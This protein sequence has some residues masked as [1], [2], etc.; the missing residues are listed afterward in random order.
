MT[1]R[2]CSVVE[3]SARLGVSTKSMNTWL[4][5]VR[6]Q[7]AKSGELDELRKENA[8][9]KSELNQIAEERDISK[10][11]PS[12]KTGNAASRVISRA[13]D[14][15]LDSCREPRAQA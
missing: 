5:I 13:S 4:S 1:E 14:L 15:H 12:S 10:S 11:T 9:L 8:R 6:G 2:N 3:V 7:A